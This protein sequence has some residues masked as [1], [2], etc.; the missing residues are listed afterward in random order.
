MLT[1]V[2][3][4]T[5]KLVVYL[6]AAYNASILFA[7]DAITG[8]VYR[9]AISVFGAELQAC[10]PYASIFLNTQVLKEQIFS[11]LTI[12][13][14]FCKNY[15][16][17]NQNSASYQLLTGVFEYSNISKSN[18]ERSNELTLKSDIYYTIF[19]MFGVKTHAVS[20]VACATEPFVLHAAQVS[21]SLS[22]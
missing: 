10:K 7:L 21:T 11:I 19:L 14:N 9:I 4:T 13:S 3:K 22:F 15:E 17:L 18:S 20:H 1:R 6:M 16:A 12:F 2:F 8:A 5:H